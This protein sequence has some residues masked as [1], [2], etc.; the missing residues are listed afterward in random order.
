MTAMSDFLELKVLDHVLGTT[1][2]TQPTSV[3]IGLSTGT[4]ADDNSGTEITGNGYARQAVTF[5]AASGGTASSNA[6]VTFPTATGTWGNIQFFGIFDAASSGN[7]LLHGA[8]SS[9]KNIT[10]GDVI[11]INSGDVTVNAT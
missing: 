11:R 9:S 5:A 6:T 8:L 1:A 10:T 2:Y 3:F 7:L 4:F